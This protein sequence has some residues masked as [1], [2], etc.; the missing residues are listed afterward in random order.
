MGSSTAGATDAGAR[1]VSQVPT[2]ESSASFWHVFVPQHLSAYAQPC[3]WNAIHCR[4]RH[5]GSGECMVVESVPAHA[6][7]FPYDG[8]LNFPCPPCSPSGSCQWPQTPHCAG[9]HW[10]R[11]SPDT[12]RTQTTA[13]QGTAGEGGRQASGASD[14]TNRRHPASQQLL[15]QPACEARTQMLQ[16][17]APRT[18]WQV[19]CD[20]ASGRWHLLPQQQ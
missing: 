17:Q 14:A 12:P 1:T 15:A 10:A 6:A 16:W 19:P 13:A 4:E 7:S 20:V 5:D 18:V 9:T 3:F 11:N 8:Q 2:A